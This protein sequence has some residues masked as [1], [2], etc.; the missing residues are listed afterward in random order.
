MPITFQ[1][2]LL[3]CG[4]TVIAETDPDANTAAAGFF[5]KTGARDEAKEL[6]GVSHFLEH[7]MF[8]GTGDMTAEELN[9]RFDQMGARNNA[10]TSAEL[11]CFHAQVLPERLPEALDLLARMMR[12]ALR[13]A[14]FQ[15][16]RG[17]ILEEIA[18]YK[19]NPFWVLYEAA[20]EQ[21]YGP[22]PMS[23]RVLGTTESISALQRDQMAGYFDQRYSADNTVVALAGALDFDASCTRIQELC[24][25]WKCTGARRD[26]H[27]PKPFTGRVELTDSKV[28][29]GYYLALSPAPAIDDPRRYAAALLAQLLGA[30]DNS[31]LHWALIETGLAE[32]AQA[33]YD[34]HDGV[35]D[36]FVFA[37]GDPDRLDEIEAVIAR[38]TA[39]LLPAITADDVERIRTKIRTAATISGERP[40]DRMQRL[41]RMW[42]YLGKYAPLE[43]ELDRL[44]KVT[45][46][47][48]HAVAA[49]FPLTPVTTGRLA[50]PVAA[51]PAAAG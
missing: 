34:A 21:Y 19:D 10:Y 51:M 23:H 2:R 12:P 30:S 26:P 41:G 22:H 45:L 46:D 17:V 25:A 43:E 44:A 6:M 9:R 27:Q 20:L 13:D 29:R 35:G 32:E 40:N 4:L 50:P 14:D 42:T 16:E 15:T 1:Q 3:P 38:E 33:A 18:M 48:L 39:A 11:T 31:R 36:Y 37:S 5:V 28:T 47:E 8:K 49:D 7:M 24:A